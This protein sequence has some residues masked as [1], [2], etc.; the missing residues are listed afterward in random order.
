MNKILNITVHCM[1]I[2]ISIPQWGLTDL[3]RTKV[4]KGIKA[5]E[6][7]QWDEALQHFQDAQ[8]D[9]PENPVGHFNLGEAHYKRKN[10]EE[11]LTS[12][13]KSLNT[14]EIDLKQQ[15]YYNLGN[16]YAQ[17]NKYQEAI[18]S[19][20]KALEIDP[21]DQDAKFN[22][23]LVRARLK[24]MAQK[25]PMENQQQQQQQQGNQQ[26]QEQ[27]QDQEQKQEQQQQ[28]QQ[29]EQKEEEQQQ[30]PQEAQKT[31]E[32]ELTKEEAERILQALKSEEKENQK[33]RKTKSSGAKGR[34]EK[35]W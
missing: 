35:D 24:E 9:D 21:D 26:N 23:E 34:V 31:Q 12:Y 20:I 5:Y 7:S 3:S 2:L 10:Y 6:E 18:Q 27:S 28:Q 4:K 22:L 14:Q 25:Q 15:I 11:A 8:L 30:Q 32:K 17:M 13:E 16:T 19:Y 29:A 33:L 1:I